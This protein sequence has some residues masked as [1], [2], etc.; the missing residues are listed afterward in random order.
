ML[1]TGTRGAIDL[2]FNILRADLHF[3]IIGDLGNHFHR[4]EGGVAAACSVKGRNAHQAMDAGLALEEAVSIGTLDHNAGR[5]EA[6][7]I[8]IEIVENLIGIAVALR[9]AGIHPV[10][11][12]AP[13]LGFGAA[14]ACLEGDQGIVAV[15]LTGEERFK[16]RLLHLLLQVFIAGLQL[17]EHRLVIFLNG[18]L[19]DGHHVVPLG[20]PY[21]HSAPS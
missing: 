11:H 19:A 18:H 17:V 21:G 2:H 20:D 12:L 7:F 4:G 10:E 16:T 6:G 1:A 13:V 9:P 14:G 8:A 5:F 15:V 3:Y